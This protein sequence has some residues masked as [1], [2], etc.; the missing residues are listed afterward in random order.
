MY[1][2]RKKEKGR[3]LKKERRREKKEI[4]IKRKRNG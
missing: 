2:H 4:Y 3:K 1:I